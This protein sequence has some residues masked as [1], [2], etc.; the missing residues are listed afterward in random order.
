MIAGEPL[1]GGLHLLGLEHR[2][3]GAD[4]PTLAGV[5]LQVDTGAM[6]AIIGPSGS[7]KS[8]L[9]RVAAGLARPDRGEVRLDGRPIT[10]LPPERR[11]LTVMFQDPHLF[12]H[13]NVLD[14]VAFAPRLNGGSRREARAVARRYLELVH[15]AGLA[16]RR[17]RELSGGQQQRVAL[18]RALAA[19]R[20]VMLLDEPFSSLDAE[21][22]RAM[23][24]LLQE[25][26]AAL[27]PTVM[28]VTHD[29]A[30]A[31]LADTV[32]VLIGGSLQQV[33][34]VADLYA[35]PASL[36]VSRLVGDF[37]EIRGTVVDG[38]HRSWWGEVPL[39]TRGLAGAATLLVRRENLAL[40]SEDAP[41]RQA[42]GV[43][44]ATRQHG[45]R[46][47]A[48]IEASGPAGG[49]RH[50]VE[51]ELP[52]GE[53]AR[54]GDRAGLHLRLPEQIWAVSDL[55]PAV[56]GVHRDPAHAGSA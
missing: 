14:N 13:L 52:F 39:P 55:S 10:H 20:R 9:L 29:L 32:A 56:S 42:D 46:Q 12:P 36:A 48:E 25:V 38:E 2:Y 21:L 50:R 47:I 45:A 22:R 28:M 30:E 37:N 49:P 43:V 33:A 51:V 7:G 19:E 8:T 18:A 15:L 24:D 5:D 44:V 53:R 40:T 17:T 31:A 23:H 41:R 11:D 1:S 35:R 16:S 6:L 4:H 54:V 26:R 27:E 3:S 34:P